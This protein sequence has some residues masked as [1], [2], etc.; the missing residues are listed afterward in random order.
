MGLLDRQRNILDYTLATLLRHKAKTVLL[1]FVYTLV[2]GVLASSVFLVSA[3]KQEAR[4]LLS[5]APEMVVQRMEA[6]RHALMP[7]DYM[8]K[9]AAI[10]GVQD[11][12]GRLW[13]YYFDSITGANYTVMV[14]ASDAPQDGNAIVGRGI[15]RA[16]DAAA[17]DYFPFRTYSGEGLNIKVTEVLSSDSELV[18]ADLF[19]V[20]ENDFRTLFGIEE[21]Y[22]TD[23][24]LSVR[25][26]RE[27]TTIASKITEGLPDTRPIIRAEMLRTYEAVFNWR[28]GLIIAIMSGAGLAFLIFAWD[29][30]SGL[31]AEEKREIAILKAIGWETSDV[32]LM[33]GWEGIVVSL[34]AFLLGTVLAYTHVF[35]F[36]SALFAPVLKGWSTLYPQFHLTPAWQPQMVMALFFLTVVPYTVAAIIPTWRAAIMDPDSVMK[37]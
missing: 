20:S 30:A 23:I 24:A 13:G 10:R 25:N 26:T 17:G 5:E 9:I 36:G 22:V 6:G 3:L 31:S 2:V 11:V 15:A 12:R 29:R 32:L 28:G 8:D 4:T 1:T 34:S 35:F 27:L 21:G 19:L 7:R 37:E 33:K 18:A 16:R 14:P